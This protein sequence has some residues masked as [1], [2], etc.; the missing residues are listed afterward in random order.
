MHLLFLAAPAETAKAHHRRHIRVLELH[1]FLLFLLLLLRK[2]LRLLFLSL[3]SFF[4][5]LVQ[6]SK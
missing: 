3:S 1:L 5:I 6:G 2:P 4:V